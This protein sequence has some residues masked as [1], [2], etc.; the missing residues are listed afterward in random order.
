MN[1][2]EL[3]EQF[4]AKVDKSGE[5]WNW[6]GTIEP[7]GY[8]RCGFARQTY[9]AH[10][11]AFSALV[12]PLVAGEYV[13][14]VCHN[15]RCVRP[16]HLQAVTGRQNSEN[17]A[18]ANRNSSTGIR[19]VSW[20]KTRGKWKVTVTSR[21]VLHNGGRYDTIAEAEA[22]AI[23]LRNRLMTNNLVDRRAS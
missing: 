2:P 10:R 19:G 15:V 21:G 6:T 8:G 23:E 13:D 4:W 5:C 7:N 16:D 3:T 18:G 22:A 14:H 12:R 17:R 1:A 11:L 20:E 9:Y